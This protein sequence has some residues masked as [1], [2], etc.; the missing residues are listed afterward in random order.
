MSETC[1]GSYR[2]IDT[3]QVALLPMLI[4]RSRIMAAQHTQGRHLLVDLV[5]ARI[6]LYIINMVSL[7]D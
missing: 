7:T 1:D 2:I 4:S 3:Y 6:R 5:Q